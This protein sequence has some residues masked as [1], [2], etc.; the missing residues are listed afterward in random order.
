MKTIRILLGASAF[1]SSLVLA[2]ELVPDAQPN[3]SKPAPF[4][5][6]GL[7]DEKRIRQEY[8]RALE[9][10]TKQPLPLVP[11]PGGNQLVWQACFDKAKADM[12]AA[13]RDA[14]RETKSVNIHIGS[15]DSDVI[16]AYGAPERTNTTETDGIVRVQYVYP[17][18]KYIYTVNGRVV[19]IQ[20]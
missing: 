20:N 6:L 1:L 19:A 11:P 18:G 3:I 7:V 13:T 9:R 12:L 4:A 10:C 14:L 15:A 16:E 8:D 5:R 2:A 17:N